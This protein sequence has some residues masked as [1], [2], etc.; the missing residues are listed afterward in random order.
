MQLI[1]SY[2]HGVYLCTH[3]CG[4]E[5][6]LPTR[7]P[8]LD[9]TSTN[10]VHLSVSHSPMVW[11][12]ANTRH[13]LR[14]D[15]EMRDSSTAMKVWFPR[16]PTQVA[17]HA[18]PKAGTGRGVMYQSSLSPSSL[19]LPSWPSWCLPN[20]K[21]SPESSSTTVWLSPH[22]SCVATPGSW[23]LTGWP[24]EREKR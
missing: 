18:S 2:E 6:L 22:A 20:V 7:K 23:T 24:L 9:L 21:T 14:D 19:D 12:L 8:T 5:V 15:S 10:V 13:W 17:L 11:E 1:Q 3:H 16:A 4:S